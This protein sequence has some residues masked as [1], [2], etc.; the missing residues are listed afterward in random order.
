MRLTN[1]LALLTALA[2]SSVYAAPIDWSVN[3]GTDLMGAVSY[4]DRDSHN[5]F[6]GGD[7]AVE[8]ELQ[9]VVQ[10]PFFGDHTT[11]YAYG[12]A[13]LQEGTLRGI[14]LVSSETYYR[15]YT[16][17]NMTDTI[18]FDLPDGVD[19]ASVRF[20]LDIEGDIRRS[21]T[22][23]APESCTTT[24]SSLWDIYLRDEQ[25]LLYVGHVSGNFGSAEQDIGTSRISYAESLVFD[26]LVT[27]GMT[28]GATFSLQNNCWIDVA[29]G[30]CDYDFG[31][32]ARA[33]IVVPA[34]INFLTGSGVFPVSVL[35]PTPQ[36][37]PEPN[38]LTLLAAGLVSAVFARR[39][40]RSQSS[41]R[42]RD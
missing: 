18:Q 42:I 37:V 32:T 2:G 27:D 3:T 6:T 22:L 1:Y 15:T 21:C 41:S 25:S 35:D 29:P 23:V 12:G 31:N 34:G 39:A 8:S 9:T 24:Y 14:G 19:S 30:I 26:L 17:A 40:R 13:N 16:Y 36:P 33:G 10:D 11:G 20:S 7:K 28:I 5:W 4:A 38:T